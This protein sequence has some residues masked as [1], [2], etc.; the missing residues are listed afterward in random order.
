MDVV[1]ARKPEVLSQIRTLQKKR[2]DM[3]ATRKVLDSGV[4]STI[5]QYLFDY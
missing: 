2:Q 4:D 3:L 1:V 5:F